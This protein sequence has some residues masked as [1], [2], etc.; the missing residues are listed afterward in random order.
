[1]LPPKE[2]WGPGPWQTEPDR[3]EWRHSSGLP[4]LIV[5]SPSTG[6]LCG[7][8]GCSPRHPLHGVDF[9]ELEGFSVHG[10]FSYGALCQGNICHTPKPGEAQHIFWLGFDCGHAFDHS[11][12]LSAVLASIGS[13]TVFGLGLGI[14]RDLAYVKREVERLAAQVAAAARP[15]PLK[16]RRL[17]ARQAR[18]HES[19]VRQMKHWAAGC[20]DRFSQRGRGYNGA[21]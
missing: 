16:L 3:L 15:V 1:M 18:R 8:V 10:G 14:Y 17:R 2:T 5:R 13:P 11:P 20:H 4:C 19:M 12:G 9:Y 6:A 7:Y 21:A